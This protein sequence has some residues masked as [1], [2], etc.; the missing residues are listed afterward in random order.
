MAKMTINEFIEEIKSLGL[1]P[2][3]EILKKL[4]SK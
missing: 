2:T 1:N 4:L 3:K